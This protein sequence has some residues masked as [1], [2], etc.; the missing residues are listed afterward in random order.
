MLAPA[1]SCLNGSPT[2]HSKTLPRGRRVKTSSV[3]W[4]VFAFCCGKGPVPSCLSAER[5][6]GGYVPTDTRRTGRTRTGCRNLPPPEVL[7]GRPELHECSRYRRTDPC[8]VSCRGAR[9]RFCFCCTGAAAHDEF[10][11]PSCE[12]MACGQLEHIRPRRE[13]RRRLWVVRLRRCV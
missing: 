12:T 4:Q 6:A 8:R 2:P 5:E 13:N 7:R 10:D 1:P 3:K 9:T 11:R